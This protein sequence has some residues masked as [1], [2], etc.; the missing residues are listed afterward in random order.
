LRSERT[1][2]LAT[3]GADERGAGGSEPRGDLV[4]RQAP[5]LAERAD[6]PAR[7]RLADGGRRL[8]ARERQR[9][10]ETAAVPG[11]TTSVPCP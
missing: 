3:C 4:D 9:R 2:V 5:E 1:R 11:A 7:E 6:A 8:E 10:Q